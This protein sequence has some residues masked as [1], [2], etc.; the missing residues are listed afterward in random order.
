MILPG[1]TIDSFTRQWAPLSN[2]HPVKIEFEG[3]EYPSVEHAFQA[4]KTYNDKIRR[5]IAKL[6]G[7]GEAKRAGREMT[8]IVPRWSEYV[9][10]AVMEQLIATKF[11]S[12]HPDMVSTLLDT[13]DALLVEGNYWHDNIWGSCVCTRVSCRRSGANALG[14]ML[15]KRREQL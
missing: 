3:I 1:C 14:R 10:F 7:A 11:S 15:M 6:N 2:F 13:G 8:I 12:A 5:D 9:R 4:A